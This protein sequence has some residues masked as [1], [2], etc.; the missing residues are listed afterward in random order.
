[1]RLITGMLADAATV[2]EGKLY[3]H[4]GGWNTIHTA[5]LPTTH[6]ALTVVLVIEFGWSETND[7]QLAVQLFDEDDQP[8]GVDAFGALQVGHPP[9][10]AQGA[11]V[12]MPLAVPFTNVTF[13]NKGRYHFKVGVDGD[14]LGRIG[15][16]INVAPQPATR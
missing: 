5:A 12:E 14:E 11:P 2:A 9:G 7:H 4:G 1:M 10:L 3:V 13:A 8:V 15:F 16:A 6:P